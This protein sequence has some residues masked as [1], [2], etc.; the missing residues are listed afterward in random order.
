MLAAKAESFTVKYV[1]QDV[2]VGRCA[3]LRPCTAWRAFAAWLRRVNPF[4][5]AKPQNVECKGQKWTV[6]QDCSSLA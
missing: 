5:T 2:K 4:E 6:A 1:M 3:K